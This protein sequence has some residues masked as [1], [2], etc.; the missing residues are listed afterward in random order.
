MPSWFVKLLE[1]TKCIHLQHI[2]KKNSCLC[3]SFNHG[4]AMCLS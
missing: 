1:L 4:C 2:I 3:Y